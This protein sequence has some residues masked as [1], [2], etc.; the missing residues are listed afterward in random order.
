MITC[1]VL[2]LGLPSTALYIVVAVTAAPALVQVGVNPL[3]AHFFVFYYG[4][5]SNVTPPVALAAYTGAGIAKAN[6]MQTAWTALRL[7]F[8]GFIIPIIIVYDPILLLQTDD[9]PINYFLLAQA[10]ISA[11]IGVY[12]LSVGFGN[13]I[14]VKL[15]IVERIILIG[16]AFFLISTSQLLDVIGLALFVIVLV[17][18]FI[19]S[20]RLLEAG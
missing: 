4:A 5:M 19:R 12:A 6:P 7:A 16:V 14:R 9:G 13:Y 15:N 8:P 3:A 17:F 11:V 1:I 10:F 18:H 20:R 2:S